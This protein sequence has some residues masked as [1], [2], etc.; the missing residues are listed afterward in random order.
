MC[1]PWNLDTHP[2]QFPRTIY[3]RRSDGRLTWSD[4][5]EEGAAGIDGQWISDREFEA[6][7]GRIFV[8]PAADAEG[9]RSGEV[10][11]KT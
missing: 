11:L 7:D 4:D 1:Q 2:E 3:L 10:C 5:R 9:K 6:A 8:C